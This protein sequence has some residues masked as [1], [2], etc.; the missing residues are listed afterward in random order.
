MN[1][2]QTEGVDVMVLER[3]GELRTE[4]DPAELPHH[5]SNPQS[6]IWY[7]VTGSE[8][9]QQGPVGRLLREIAFIVGVHVLT[10]EREL[11]R[12]LAQ[13]GVPLRRE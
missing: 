8:G 12:R 3:S 7:D 10:V 13:N 9:D 11:G 2:A 1:R 4:V 6:L 5:L